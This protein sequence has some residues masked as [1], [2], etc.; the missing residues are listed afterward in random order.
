[1]TSSAAED[2]IKRIYQDDRQLQSELRMFI[3]RVVTRFNWTEP[4]TVDDIAQDCW[5]KLLRNLKAGSFEGRSSVKTYLY[6]IARRTCIDHFRAHKAIDIVDP[7]QVV[8]VD[9][10]LSQEEKLLARERRGMAAQVLM[11][12]SRECRRL[13]RKVFWKRQTYR[14]IAEQLE[15]SEGS[16]KRKM[17]ECRQRAQKALEELDTSEPSV[18]R[19]D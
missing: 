5:L 12:L 4:E 11:R 10:G 2:L 1:M 19:D 16:V 6:T 18:G 13:W 14:Q 3:K 8:L 7:D 9:P 17:W 15:L